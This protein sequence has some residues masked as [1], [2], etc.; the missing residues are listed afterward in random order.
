MV[1][2]RPSFL[3][4]FVLI[5]S[6]IAGCLFLASCGNGPAR[7][8]TT[9]Q[10]G[11]GGLTV[12]AERD[13][14]EKSNPKWTVESVTVGDHSSVVV[15]RDYHWSLARGFAHSAEYHHVTYGHDQRVVSWVSN[16]NPN[17]TKE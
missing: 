10:T 15:Y 1:T 11:A 12:G 2:P 16:S 5:L 17:Q 6:T 4:T 13:A 3:R 9:E 14:I 8:S 7:S